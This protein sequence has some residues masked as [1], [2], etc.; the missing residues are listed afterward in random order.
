VE[1]AVEVEVEVEAEVEAEV[2]AE[3]VAT[4]SAAVGMEAAVAVT[5]DG[6]L[7]ADASRERVDDRNEDEV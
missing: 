4:D 1:V 5:E 3:A 2:K 6:A 7:L